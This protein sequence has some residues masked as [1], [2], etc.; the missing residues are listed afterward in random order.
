[1]KGHLRFLCSLLLWAGLTGQYA[2]ADVVEDWGAIALPIEEETTF[3]FAQYD[4]DQNFTDLYTFSLEG[5]AGAAYSVT[6]DFDPCRAGCGS[7]ELSYGIYDANGG[8]ITD[9]GG[10]V[11]LSA[12]NYVFQVKGIGMGAG[13]ALD[14]WGSVTFSATAIVPPVP[15]PGTLWL[16]APGVV[17]LWQH[18]E[19]LRRPEHRH[20]TRELA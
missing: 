19:R 12:G 5:E 20:G 17:L 6:F 2:Q 10:A 13:N 16:L 4:I 9:T 7:P 14:Y 18:R 1:M 3:S 8:L 11:T 15:E